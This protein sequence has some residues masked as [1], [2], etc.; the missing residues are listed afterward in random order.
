MAR[1]R[2]KQRL[3]FWWALPWWKQR[4]LVVPTTPAWLPLARSDCRRFPS[5]WSSIESPSLDNKQGSVR[6]VSV[7]LKRYIRTL[8]AIYRASGMRNAAQRRHRTNDRGGWWFNDS[9]GG[10]LRLWFL[11][12]ET[13][14][15]RGLSTRRRQDTRG[16]A[17]VQI[18]SRRCTVKN[19]ALGLRGI[20]FGREGK[21]NSQSITLPTPH[22]T[23]PY[24][25]R[26]K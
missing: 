18:E 24:P 3:V 22:N 8:K 23:F 20:P 7:D 5:I 14:R 17:S 11:R 10:W 6:G 2:P 12:K 16:G 25:G 4:S 19:H 13:K 15:K 9:D 1:R 21:R 26:T